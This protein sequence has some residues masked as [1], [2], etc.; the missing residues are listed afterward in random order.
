MRTSDD[1]TVDLVWT[2]PEDESATVFELEQ[3]TDPTFGDAR[4]RYL[5]SDQ[6]SVLTGLREGTY[7]FRVRA[8]DDGDQPGEWSE[9]LVLTVQYMGRTPLFLLLGTGAV[10]A[11]LTMAAIISGFLKNR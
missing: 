11:G 10:V 3:A 1:G 9:P 5:G 4:Q 8:I 6:E 7:H 2:L